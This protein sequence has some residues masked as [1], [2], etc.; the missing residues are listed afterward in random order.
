MGFS[1]VFLNQVD[2]QVLQLGGLTILRIPKRDERVDR[3]WKKNVVVE[4]T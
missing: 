4:G 3:Q 1:S 2:G